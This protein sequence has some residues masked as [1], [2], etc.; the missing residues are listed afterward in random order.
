VGGG[1]WEWAVV[2]IVVMDGGGECVS[3]Q[4]WLCAFG[5]TQPP[6]WYLWLVFY[7]PVRSSFSTPKGATGNRNR[8]QLTPI[9]LGPQPDQV[10]PV[11][12]GPV[13]SK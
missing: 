13:V 4:W 9:L 10:Q 7:G 3:W 11:P 8:S 5:N 1:W 6:Y 2:G 12:I